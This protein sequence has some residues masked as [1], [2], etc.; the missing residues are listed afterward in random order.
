M[1][2][3]SDIDADRA[4]FSEEKSAGIKQAQDALGGEAVGLQG[5]I[6]RED[7]AYTTVKE[8]KKIGLGTK[9]KADPEV[10]F[11]RAVRGDGLPIWI[12]FNSRNLSDYGSV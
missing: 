9:W 10:I 11:A 3:V 4:E 2:K 5:N 8:L 1:R 7:L 6:T 12:G